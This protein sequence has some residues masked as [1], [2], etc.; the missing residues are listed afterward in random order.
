MHQFWWRDTP[1]GEVDFWDESDPSDSWST[2]NE[3]GRIESELDMYSKAGF[4][5]VGFNVDKNGAPFLTAEFDNILNY[6][7][8]NVYAVDYNMMCLIS[9]YQTGYQSGLKHS[10]AL[11]GMNTA[12]AAIQ[13]AVGLVAGAAAYAASSAGQAAASAKAATIKS[14]TEAAATILASPTGFSKF[15]F[16]RNLVKGILS[17]MV[18]E[19]AVQGFLSL[20]N[21]PGWLSEAL[22]ESIGDSVAGWGK[23]LIQTT[24]GTSGFT[25]LKAFNQQVRLYLNQQQLIALT[26]G[27]QTSSI[28]SMLDNPSVYQDA[29][30]VLKSIQAEKITFMI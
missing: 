22:G 7:D 15:S 13:V 18:V 29:F 27:L 4:D 5:S 2:H 24:F 14:L 23:N 16:I 28:V 17:E 21:C 3:I 12:L 9:K 1:T 20:I 19:E 6:S 26:E 8:P 10:F 30:K 25:I 11:W